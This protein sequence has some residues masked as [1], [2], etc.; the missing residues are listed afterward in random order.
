M[1]SKPKTIIAHPSSFLI[2]LDELREQN[3]ITQLEYSTVVKDMPDILD[4]VFERENKHNNITLDRFSGLLKIS[5]ANYERT[6]DN[7]YIVREKWC[8]DNDRVHRDND[9]PAYITYH[10]G[11][12][13]KRTSRWFTGGVMLPRVG[14]GPNWVEWYINGNPLSEQWYSGENLDGCVGEKWK[15]ARIV[16]NDDSSIKLREWWVAGKRL[17]SDHGPGSEMILR[18]S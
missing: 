13:V 9:K 11:S 1:R 4:N 6:Y 8:D 18:S 7:S 5:S 10:D 14:D 17:Q 3:K 15:P 2:L 12:R 16:Y